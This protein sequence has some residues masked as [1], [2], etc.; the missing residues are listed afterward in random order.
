MNSVLLITLSG[1]DRAGLVQSLAALVVAHDANWEQSRML[2]LAGHFVG[3]LQVAVPEAKAHALIK[4]LRELG[5]LEL[6]I[7]EGTLSLPKP[8]RTLDI[9]I[10]GADHPGI[11]AEIFGAL[12]QVGLNVETLATG[13]ETAPD[14]GQALFRA[15]AQ[16]SSTVA[17]DLDALRGVLEA[18]AADL[19]VDVTLNG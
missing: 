4:A 7:A 15:Q 8:E 10:L 2:H 14:S 18:I 12:A 19:V 16:L 9:E 1:L 13:T 3:I 6:T 17:V 11:V 5:D